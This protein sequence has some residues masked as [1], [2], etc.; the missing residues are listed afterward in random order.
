MSNKFST[1]KHVLNNALHSLVGFESIEEFEEVLTLFFDAL[2]DPIFVIDEGGNFIKVLGGNASYL[3]QGTENFE[4]KCIKDIFSPT[5]TQ[6]FQLAINEAINFNKL[7]II[8]HEI[9]SNDLKG[10]EVD[11]SSTF[12]EGRIHPIRQRGNDKRAV[13]CVTINNTEKKLMEQ[14]L[15]QLADTDPL[16]AAY[17]RR[18]FNNSVSRA[19]AEFTRY[20][21]V[22]S[23]LMIDVDHFK[24]FN[25]TFG[26]DV[27][28][29][30]LKRLVK[31]C[32][33]ILRTIDI[34]AR[35]GGEEFMILLPSTTCDNACIVANR[36][37]VA[38][39]QDTFI[40]GNKTISYTVSI[41][42]TQVKTSDK[43]IDL[44]TK[45]A[46]L[47]LYKAKDTG[48]NQVCSKL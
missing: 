16:T 35:Y 7:V 47:A 3:Y 9:N 45:R 32:N 22:F 31:I 30:V 19:L 24:K 20:N 2:P 29:Q 25:D 36:I 15:L 18:F 10:I 38:I 14:K 48:R 6:K 39:E 1:S 41:G 44:L 28:D 23:L 5:L 26:H 21:T 33:S 12:F 37:R 34:F 4:G 11:M 13:L 42:A 40:L 46:D 43:N 27:G 8:E 17:N